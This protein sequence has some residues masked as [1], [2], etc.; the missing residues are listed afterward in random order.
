[1]PTCLVI[2]DDALFRAS[3]SETLVAGGFEVR[4]AASGEEGFASYVDN[5]TDLVILDIFLPDVSGHELLER[6]FERD[7]SGKVVIV[8]SD[9]SLDSALRSLRGGAGDYLP[10]P[11]TPDALR[12]SV[13]RVLERQALEREKHE[14]S[15][16]LHRRVSDLKMVR[17]ISQLVTS[18]RPIES[19]MD[20]VVRATCAFVGAEA[21]SLLLLDADRDELYFYGSAGPK[22][23]AVREI[24]LPRERGG[25]AWWSLVNRKPIKVDDAQSDERF[26]AEVDSGTGFVTRCILAAPI[27]VQDDCIGVI[28]LLNKKQSDT[29][30]DSDLFRLEEISS[31]IAVTVQNA[32][33]AGD[34]RKSRAE[35]AAWSQQLE[36]T[37]EERT[38]ALK[39]AN[40]ARREAY[41]QLEQTHRRLKK[42]QAGM[43]RQEKMA[44]IGLLGAGVAHEINNPLGFVNANLSTLE[45]YVRSLRRLAGVV[46]HAGHRAGA[47]G[48]E[49]IARIMSEAGRIVAEDRLEEVI[50]DLGPL[51]DEMSAGLARIT[52][53]VEQLRAFAEE[54]DLDGHPAS[55]D[56][57]TEVERLA[58]LVAGTLL[59]AGSSIERDLGALPAVWLPVKSLRQ[60]LLG[61]L[62]VRTRAGSRACLIVLSTR[63]R[64]G[65]VQIDLLDRGGDLDGDDLSRLFDPFFEPG[66]DRETGGLGLAAAHGLARMMGGRLEAF[67][68]PAGGVC[69]RLELPA[70]Q[71]QHLAEESA[72]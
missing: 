10:K 67:R 40:R 42:A 46:I 18:T 47:D 41:E 68:P 25:I 62:G 31:T 17:Y 1:M 30:D 21:G 63:E 32:M 58:E 70:A 4:E 13:T 26:D 52:T 19:W 71:K 12:M 24:R 27:V 36:K 54:G 2:D 9:F 50:E 55:V 64:E 8:T 16:E 56:V 48:P 38:R 29:F 72:S 43:I 3:A 66:S 22:G 15:I 20:E 69:L 60:V 33:V 14:L 7:E 11:F 39:V 49:K 53:I 61:M 44:S 51:F 34:L 5:P 57:N 59:T 45:Q 28:E 37:V 6:F 65:R 23:D 35:L